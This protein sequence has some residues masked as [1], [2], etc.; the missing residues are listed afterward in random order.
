MIKMKEE[1]QELKYDRKVM[2]L[3]KQHQEKIAQLKEH[4]NI[5]MNKRLQ[6]ESEQMLSMYS[7]VLARLPDINAK[8]RM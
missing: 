6:K 4:Y 3:E 2:E 8:L 7:D 5:E 1:R